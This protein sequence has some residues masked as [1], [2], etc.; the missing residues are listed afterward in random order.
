MR[1]IIKTVLFVVLATGAIVEGV[2]LCCGNPPC[3]PPRLC[4]VPR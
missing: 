2:K 3:M 1:L 4:E